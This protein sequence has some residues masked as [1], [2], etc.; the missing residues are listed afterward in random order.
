MRERARDEQRVLVGLRGR[1]TL[2]TAPAGGTWTH[3]LR[4]GGT[5]TIAWVAGESSV[6]VTDHDP[7][8]NEIGSDVVPIGRQFSAG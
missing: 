5:R 8:G 6:T 1:Y 2:P 7:T 4:A 3:E